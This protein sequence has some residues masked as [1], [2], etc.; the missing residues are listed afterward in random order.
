MNEQKKQP[1]NN[2][3]NQHF[4]EIRDSDKLL[5]TCVSLKSVAK[6]YQ[7]NFLRQAIRNRE[8]YLGNQYL[9]SIGDKL[10]YR[11]RIPGQEWRPQTTR[12]MVG[13]T[14]DPNHAII[15]SASPML[16]I[17]PIFPDSPVMY[18][19]QMPTR[20]MMSDSA[21]DNQLQESE[22]SGRETGESA[23]EYL[24]N[25]WDSPYRKEY[26]A[27]AIAI[28]D[29]L[30]SGTSFRGYGV[31]KHPFRG[32]EV[33]VKNLQPYQ[34]L[35]DPEGRDMVT[36]S[37]F[38]YIIIVSHL[39]VMSIKRRWPHASEQDYGQDND[40][41]RYDDSTAGG[42]F[43]RIFK[44][45]PARPADKS[46][47]DMMEEWSLRRY[48]VYT[49]FYAGWMPDL[50]VTNERTLAESEE[51]PY[52]HG[53]SVT[54]I[55]DKKIVEDG[56]IETWGFTFPIIALTPNPI[57]H[58]GYGQADATKLIGPQDLIN[59]F[60]NIIVSNAILNGH[61]QLLIETGALN[62][63]TF[64]V[65]PGAIMNLAR[66]ALRTGRIKQ[67][68]PGP[69]GAEIIQFMMNLE[70][71]TK[72]EVGDADG[73]LRGQA[74]GQVTSGLHARTI[75]E[76]AFTQKSFRIGLLDDAYE[77]GAFKE[78]N[79]T[80]QY[81]PLSNNYNR[82]YMGIKEGMDLAMQ[83][84]LFKV[85]KESRKDLPFSSGGQFELY[86]AMLRQGDITHK[87]FFELVKFHIDDQWQ[88]KV[89][90][91]AKDAIPGLPP[92][93]MAQMHLE[94]AA[95]A[96][97]A[98]AIGGETIGARGGQPTGAGGGQAPMPPNDMQVGNVESMGQVEEV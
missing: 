10:E 81:V 56:D 85:E 35:L 66:D 72:E 2:T 17:K 89:D 22:Y 13:Q 96:E 93:V 11:R 58:S 60:S 63:Q 5:D 30:L 32:A 52:P 98:A 43:S 87:Q 23:T 74:S 44:T 51:F 14:I 3:K 84:L 29:S 47:A 45:D 15:A 90:E 18:N 82:G 80:Q 61:T 46:H 24:G 95:A 6:E 77:L 12:N 28:L 16:N 70:Q 53:R 57:P 27:R 88:E 37:D 73:L 8:Y 9:R 41:I 1:Q 25:V 59:A 48:P 92:D 50:L 79:L 19:P 64:S 33:I 75:Q 54:W 40:N 91:A 62:P 94:S 7:Q 69:L 39:D 86:F 31:K 20:N 4:L 67:L 76:S 36:L 34:V 78:Y 71:F 68:F 97:Q 42:F 83:N 26:N 21:Y 38:R 55:N 65:R 49:L